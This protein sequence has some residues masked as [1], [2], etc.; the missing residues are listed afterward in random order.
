MKPG[1]KFVMSST[2]NTTRE[3]CLKLYCTYSAVAHGSKTALIRTA[4]VLRNGRLVE[5]ADNDDVTELI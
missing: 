1:K 5:V 3:I 4:V 2:D